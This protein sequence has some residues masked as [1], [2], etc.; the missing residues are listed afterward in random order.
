MRILENLG[1]WLVETFCY[2]PNPLE[3]KR[4]RTI[5]SKFCLFFT[6]NPNRVDLDSL[7]VVDLDFMHKK[8]EVEVH[9]HLRSPGRLIG[10][11][12][13]TLELLTNHLNNSDYK[14]TIK[15]SYHNPF[16]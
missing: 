6:S 5:K 14:V 9:V 16:A 11:E 7:G 10:K 12:G 8:D 4:E 3:E 1:W 13:K 2:K 15:I